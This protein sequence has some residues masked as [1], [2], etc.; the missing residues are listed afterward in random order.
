MATRRSKQ[1]G[2][3]GNVKRMAQQLFSVLFPAIVDRQPIPVYVPHVTQRAPSHQITSRS[4]S[5]HSAFF[6][7]QS[8]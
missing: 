1:F 5:S 4:V 3:A 7:H 2:L 6:G 8:R